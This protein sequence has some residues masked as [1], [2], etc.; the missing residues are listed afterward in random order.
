MFFDKGTKNMSEGSSGFQFRFGGLTKAAKVLLGTAHDGIDTLEHSISDALDK[1]I[2][3][4]LLGQYDGLVKTGLNHREAFD[5]VIKL[6]KRR[7]KTAIQEKSQGD[8]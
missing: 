8:V 2:V 7:L 6:V 5:T 3:D 4:R 1:Q